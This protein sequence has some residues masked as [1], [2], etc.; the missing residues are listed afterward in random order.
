MPR[1]RKI[2][3]GG[4]G[5]NPE[6]QPP[7]TDQKQQSASQQPAS[8]PPSPQVSSKGDSGVSSSSSTSLFYAATNA[9]SWLVFGKGG[10][11]NESIKTVKGEKRMYNGRLRSVHM[12]KRGGK[13]VL[14]SGKKVYL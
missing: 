14:V 4:D 13:Y 9:L 1:S 6:Q 2:I 12:G 10:G 7:S 3:K 8:L 11:K 5:D